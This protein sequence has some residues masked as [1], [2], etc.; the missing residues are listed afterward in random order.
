MEQFEILPVQRVFVPF[1]E[2]PHL[3]CIFQILD[4]SRIPAEL[5]VDRDCRVIAQVRHCRHTRLM[6]PD[7]GASALAK[8]VGSAPMAGMRM[9]Q[10]NVGQPGRVESV[11]DHVV[12]DFV[13]S[14]TKASIDDRQSRTAIEEV[15]IAIERMAQPELLAAGE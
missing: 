11:G 5:L 4:G 7:L 8:P 12:D 6:N 15:T 2:K 13:R 3:V 9:G 1:A 14:Q 10:Q